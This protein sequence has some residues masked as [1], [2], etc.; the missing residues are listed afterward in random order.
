MVVVVVVVVVAT[1]VVDK[2]HVISNLG[3]THF[4]GDYRCS[5]SFKADIFAPASKI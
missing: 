3:Q 1:V 4:F 5:V 2:V